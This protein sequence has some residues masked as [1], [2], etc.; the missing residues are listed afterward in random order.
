[1]GR[2][3]CPA[4]V[5]LVLL[6]VTFFGARTAGAADHPRA[7]GM[8]A[9]PGPLVLYALG[10]STVSG[11][12]ARA[13][14]YADRVFA[15]L[16]RA[17]R[18][19]RLVN[20]AESGATAA[21]VLRDQLPRVKLA[22]KALVIV[23]VGAN[24]LT[25]SVDPELFGRHFEAILI[26]L[27]SRTAGPIVVS[28]LPD[29]SLASAVWPALRA[30]LAARVDVY[31]AVIAR[32][33]GKHGVAVYDVCTMTRQQLPAHPEY[34]SGDGYHPSDLGYEVWAEGLWQIVQRVL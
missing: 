17:G 27:R 6:A 15:R 1:M 33:A 5:S 19:L 21:D 25:G 11:V 9:A 32:I 12:G 34:L 22:Q 20:L 26:G 8:T 14:S 2:V 28:N 30:P 24:D 7:S 10:D 29:V 13:G 31:N 18:G 4:S 23:G 16:A 3:V